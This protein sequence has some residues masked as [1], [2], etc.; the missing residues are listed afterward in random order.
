MLAQDRVRADSRAVELVRTGVPD[1]RLPK[2]AVAAAGNCDGREA[3]DHL[4]PDALAA[5]R[6]RHAQILQVEALARPRAVRV[7]VRRRARERSV[8]FRDEQVEFARRE[9]PREGLDGRLQ[10]VERVVLDRE[11][12]DAELEDAVDVPERDWVL[13]TEVV[14]VD[15]AVDDAEVVTVDDAV[16]V[17]VTRSHRSSVKKLPSNRTSSSTSLSDSANNEQSSGT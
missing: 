12:A 10:L 5:V 1:L 11:P 6:R 13:V 2:H 17:T 7:L 15:V 16:V 8:N 9:G 4:R 14:A 3:T